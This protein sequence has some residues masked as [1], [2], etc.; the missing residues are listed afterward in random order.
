M[1][2]M[3]ATVQRFS[4]LLKRHELVLNDLQKI[5]SRPKIRGSYS[6]FDPLNVIAKKMS[7]ISEYLAI[8]QNNLCD[9]ESKSDPL[10]II[11]RISNSR[12]IQ[13]SYYSSITLG[14]EVIFDTNINFYRNT[15][16]IEFFQCVL[17][18]YGFISYLNATCNGRE[19]I[20]TLLDD[21]HETFEKL[22]RELYTKEVHVDQVRDITARNAPLIS[23]SA[24]EFSSVIES[25]EVR[26]TIPIMNLFSVASELCVMRDGK[27]AFMSINSKRFLKNKNFGAHL[28]EQFLQ[29]EYDH[30]N[31]GRSLLFQTLNPAE[32]KILQ[33]KNSEIELQIKKC[34]ATVL[35]LHCNDPILWEQKWKQKF[36]IWCN[37]DIY[38]EK[39]SGRVNHV[40]QNF[41]EKNNRLKE[42]ANSNDTLGIALLSSNQES[43]TDNEHLQRMTE[44]T[45]NDLEKLNYDKLLE[46]DHNLNAELSP[47]MV[48]SPEIQNIRSASQEFSLSDSQEIAHDGMEVSDSESVISELESDKQIESIHTSES[49]FNDSPISYKPSFIRKKKSSSLISL[50]SSRSNLK[51][52]KPYKKLNYSMRS[53]NRGSFE[54]EINKAD[55]PTASTG[56]FQEAIEV[57]TLER[58]S[59]HAKINLPSHIKLENSRTVF[60]D[61]V[62]RVSY[63]NNNSWQQFGSGPLKL[64]LICFQDLLPV[65]LIT[66]E[67]TNSRLYHVVL[68][69]STHCKCSRSSAQDIQLHAPRSNVVAYEMGNDQDAL[70]MTIRSPK[71]ES[72][73]GALL[74]TIRQANRKILFE[75]AYGSESGSTG[76]SSSSSGLGLFSRS[77]TQHTQL[78][79]VTSKPQTDAICKDVKVKHHV[80]ATNSGLWRVARV[81]WLTLQWSAEPECVTVALVSAP[82][83]QGEKLT[84]VYNSKTSDIEPAGRTGIIFR[85]ATESEQLFEFRNSDVAHHVLQRLRQV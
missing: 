34:N 19:K 81:G 79:A 25:V 64:K 80:R 65:L 32:F 62:A 84:H 22:Y 70:I 14:L 73:M 63:W 37:S 18:T 44:T 77:S 72:V 40:Y 24:F 27:L 66:D 17:Q 31:T 45:L 83:S 46:L 55:N 26:L 1:L 15:K 59:L 39:S 35:K 50:I 57:E 51:H 7:S 9:F 43:R 3:S 47:L 30:L 4:A 56:L 76:S 85:D 48:Y 11:E 61:S 10:T 8:L 38:D 42:I 20:K 28:L 5:C 2:L 29:G 23:S 49:I 13:K 21:I 68:T 54:S 16:N 69:I 36:N 6:A 33:Q 78:T 71:I 74:S 52:N 75:Q 82:G 53:L 41:I 12:D 67:N 58:R 60:E